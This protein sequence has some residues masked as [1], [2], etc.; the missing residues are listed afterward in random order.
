MTFRSRWSYALEIP[1]VDSSIGGVDFSGNNSGPGIVLFLPSSF[2][3]CKLGI[4]NVY[5]KLLFVIH[6][7]R[8]HFYVEGGCLCEHVGWGCHCGW[9][10]GFLYD[11]GGF[12]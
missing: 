6:I 9:L 8:C 10:G 3:L 4:A 5:P 12:L 11:M 1:Q 7:M 2:T